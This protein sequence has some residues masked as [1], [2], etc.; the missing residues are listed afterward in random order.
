MQEFRTDVKPYFFLFLFFYLSIRI[1]NVSR[2][3]NSPQNRQIKM[4]WRPA[5]ARKRDQNASRPI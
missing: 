2:K 3:K 4:T 5:P 1:L